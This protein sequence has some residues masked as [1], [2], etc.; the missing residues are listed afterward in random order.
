MYT[1]LI[2]GNDLQD[3]SSIESV[4][5]KETVRR[6]DKSELKTHDLTRGKYS[7]IYNPKKLKDYTNKMKE[8][9]TLSSEFKKSIKVRIDV[10]KKLK[11]IPVFLVESSMDGEYIAVPGCKCSVCVPNSGLEEMSGKLG[12]YINSN[13]D[14]VIP[15]RI[16]IWMD[17]IFNEAKKKTNNQGIIIENAQTL[18][19]LVL[20]HEMAHAMMDVDLY[21]V[22]PA[23]NFSYSSSLYKF[24]EEAYADGIAYKILK[25]N[26]CTPEKQGFIENSISIYGKILCNTGIENVFA[27]YKI[28]EGTIGKWMGIKVHFDDKIEKKLEKLKN[29]WEEAK[30]KEDNS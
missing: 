1:K 26:G 11:T 7:T 19:D 20:Y 18:F 5:D 10:L 4:L 28:D 22:N 13:E 17:K 6:K 23:D 9:S 24:F 27:T 30:A 15:R 2:I 16:F 21:G 29:E 8:L 25:D 3:S 12:I 14:D